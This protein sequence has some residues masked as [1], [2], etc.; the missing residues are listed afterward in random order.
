MRKKIPNAPKVKFNGVFDFANAKTS[1]AIGWSQTFKA[2]QK[3][4]DIG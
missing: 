1:M 4:P 2:R 3:K